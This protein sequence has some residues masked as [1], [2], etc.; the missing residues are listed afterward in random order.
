MRPSSSAVLGPDVVSFPP[1]L[2]LIIKLVKGGG[3]ENVL[4]VDKS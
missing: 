1:W 3:A 4:Y 2:V